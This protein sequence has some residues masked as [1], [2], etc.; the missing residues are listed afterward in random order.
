MR[1]AVIIPTLNEAARIGG[2][3]AQL[4]RLPPETVATIA[5]ADGGSTDATRALVAEAAARDPRIQLVDNPARL[6][7]AGINR[8]V[9]VLPNDIRVF[10]RIDAH[11]AYPEDYIPRVLGVMAMT[12]VP[13]IA[14][15]LRTVGRTCTERG[16]AAASNSRGGNGGSAHRLGG[17][18]GYVDHGHHAGIDRA[19][20]DRLGGYDESFD[21]NEDAEFDL[22]VRRAGAC[23]W[24]AAEIEVDYAPRGT[25]AA[26]AR[27]YYRYGRGRAR[28]FQKHGERLR[29]RQML[30]PAVLVTV[31]GAVLL[32]P[33]VPALL[34]L[35]LLYLLLIAGLTLGLLRAAP[36]RC[37]LLAAPA[38]VAM[39]L[40]W[41][42]GF[43]RQLAQGSK[44]GTNP[45][46]H[47]LNPAQER[48]A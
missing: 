39:H 14:T 33:V 37:T 24:L 23:I 43:L 32:A 36:S 27:Q 31:A 29:L 22:R 10:V 44:H 6:Q 3:L 26:L 46:A 16:I 35:P 41:G 9:A 13:M 34:L 25:L 48:R 15:R 11:A 7:S 38:M 42:A 28:T 5:V 2:L 17:A 45:P 19:L 1:A 30:P 8:A 12:G 40:A 47:A 18:S 20:F 4:S 21:T